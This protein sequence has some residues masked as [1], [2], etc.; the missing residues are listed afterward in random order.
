MIG[1]FLLTG[2]HSLLGPRLK[3]HGFELPVTISLTRSA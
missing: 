1:R 3:A 2:T